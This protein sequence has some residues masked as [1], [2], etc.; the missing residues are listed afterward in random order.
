LDIAMATGQGSPLTPDLARALTPVAK[1]IVEPL[2]QYGVYAAEVEPDGRRRRGRAARLPGPLPRLDSVD[3]VA[4]PPGL[5]PG[6]LTFPVNSET[7]ITY[8]V[9]AVCLVHTGAMMRPGSQRSGVDLGFRVSF[10]HH[11]PPNPPASPNP[12]RKIG[13]PWHERATRLATEA[14]LT[15]EAIGTGGVSGD[16]RAQGVRGAQGVGGTADLGAGWVGWGWVGVGWD[17]APCGVV[18]GCGGCR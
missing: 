11:S 1:S 8:T 13:P 15:T 16:E 2:R 5:G 6:G 17:P 4:R 12:P 10:V 14:M 7:R 9:H 18:T 3:T